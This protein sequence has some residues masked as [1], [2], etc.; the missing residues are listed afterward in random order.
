MRFVL[1]L[2]GEAIG[3]E[4][5]AFDDVTIE[6]I[7]GEIACVVSKGV[8]VSLVVGGGNLWRNKS[9]NNG[10]FTLDR[11]KSDQIGMMGTIMNALYLSEALRYKGV[12]AKVMTPFVVGTFTEQFSV[13]K[14]NEY[15]D[16]GVV[17]I[18]AGG[19]GHPF[20]TTDSITALR[21]A[22]LKAVALY[23]KN[24][25]G[26]Y[27]SD[28]RTNTNAVRYKSISY[29]NVIK[30]GLDALDIAAMNISKDAGTKSLIFALSEP[31]S[32]IEACG[33]GFSGGTIITIDA[34][35][36]KVCQI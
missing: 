10:S 6:R 20:F 4:K 9:N 24:I 26:V 34:E 17:V 35:E 15:L 8:Q 33:S 5:S 30:Y 25:D 18:N 19:T 3:G 7:C 36:E 31:G 13:D 27:D 23:A 14:A 1:K 16:A 21:A 11:S 32:I 22:E 2:S 12:T 29:D 28:P